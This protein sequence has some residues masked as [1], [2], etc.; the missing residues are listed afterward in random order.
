MLASTGETNI[1]ARM[2][3]NPPRK[4]ETIPSPSAL[5]A[6]PC[7]AMGY[8]SNVVAIDA[9]VPGMFIKIAAIRPPEKPPMYTPSRRARPSATAMRNVMGRNKAIAI[10]VERP[11]MAPKINPTTTPNKINPTLKKLNMEKAAPK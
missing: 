5:P 8:P 11:G 3:M 9:A 4:L 10:V 7:M 1:K 2:E 6:L